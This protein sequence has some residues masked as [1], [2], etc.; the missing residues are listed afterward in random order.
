MKH[1]I[2]TIFIFVILAIPVFAYDCPFSLIDDPNPG[3]C[4]LYTDANKDSLCD[5]SQDLK[6]LLQFNSQNQGINNNQTKTN[7]MNY[8]ISHIILLFII[9]Q[10][11]GVSLIQYKKLKKNMWRKINNYALLAGFIVVLFT[12]IITLFNLSGLAISKNISFVR[13]NNWLHAEAGLI[14]ILFC[15]EHAVR[16]WKQF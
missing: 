5:N 12:S 15:V 13:F 6:E 16:R 2:A 11:T 1:L 10:L 3:S 7:K 4:T 9:F 8:Y 14:M